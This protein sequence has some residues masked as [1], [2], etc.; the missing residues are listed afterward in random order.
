MLLGEEIWIFLKAAWSKNWPDMEHNQAHWEASSSQQTLLNHM[1]SWKRWHISSQ[2][3]P[4][5]CRLV[6]AHGCWHH[7]NTGLVVLSRHSTV[8]VPSR[9]IWMI[10]RQFVVT[11]MQLCRPSFPLP[12]GI[13]CFI[14]SPLTLSLNP[15]RPVADGL[16]LILLKEDLQP[17]AFLPTSILIELSWQWTWLQLMEWFCPIKIKSL[18]VKFCDFRTSLYKHC[19][20]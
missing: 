8:R 5:A 15:S 12:N 4:L 7:L 1:S 14:Q 11:S 17:A 3:K 6:L 20:L 13:P 16:N 18:L 2:C 19:S 10:K 9:I